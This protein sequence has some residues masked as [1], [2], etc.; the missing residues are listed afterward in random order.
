[1]ERSLALLE[2]LIDE[3][4]A[5]PSASTI[6][7]AVIKL[8]DSPV[9]E[10]VE[11]PLSL[12]T[13]SEIQKAA[14]HTSASPSALPESLFFSAPSTLATALSSIQVSSTES[15]KPTTSAPV[16]VKDAIET[17]I[18]NASLFNTMKSYYVEELPE[19]GTVKANEKIKRRDLEC[20]IKMR[21]LVK[22]LVEADE[23]NA[24]VLHQVTSLCGGAKGLSF[25]DKYDPDTYFIR[26]RYGYK[27]RN[28]ENKEN[29]DIASRIDFEALFR[30][31][32]LIDAGVKIPFEFII[33]L[34]SLNK[35]LDHILY[36]ECQTGK[37]SE[38]FEGMNKPLGDVS[39]MKII[40]NFVIQEYPKLIFEKFN[41]EVQE[42]CSIRLADKASVYIFSRKFVILGELLHELS[43]II[44]DIKK[45]KKNNLFSLFSRFNGLRNGFVHF[46]FHVILYSLLQE[47][48]LEPVQAIISQILENL[49]CLCNE[50]KSLTDEIEK[51]QA[52]KLCK[53]GLDDLLEL[54]QPNKKRKLRK[55]LIEIVFLGNH[56]FE[57]LESRAYKNFKVFL[58]ENYTDF[59]SSKAREII[60]MG[61]KNDNPSQLLALESCDVGTDKTV[62]ELFK[63]FLDELKSF[64][65]EKDLQNFKREY[66]LL[67]E[68]PDNQMFIVEKFNST[69][70]LGFEIDAIKFGDK[71]SIKQ[72]LVFHKEF[73]K[74]P[75][76]EAAKN[77]S[78]FFNKLHQAL[79]KHKITTPN[80]SSISKRYKDAK[81]KLS[82]LELEDKIELEKE[83]NFSIVLDDFEEIQKLLK[84]ESFFDHFGNSVK[85]FTGMIIREMNYLSEI[86]LNPTLFMQNCI[87]EH[88]ITLVG[89]YVRDIED[90]ALDSEVFVSYTSRVAGKTAKIYRNKG[91]AH[92]LFDFNK[93]NFLEGL[94]ANIYPAVEDFQAIHLIADSRSEIKM[95]GSSLIYAKLGWSYAQLSF[96]KEA[97]DFY[98]KA[99]ESFSSEIPK[100]EFN[101]NSLVGQVYLKGAG[102]TQPQG[103]LIDF[104][105]FVFGMS[106]FELYCYTNLQRICFRSGNLEKV[107]DIYTLFTSQI[108]L[109]RVNKYQKMLADPSIDD[110]GKRDN[111]SS[112]E[113]GLSELFERLIKSICSYQRPYVILSDD[114][115]LFGSIADVFAGAACAERLNGNYQE[116]VKLLSYSVECIIVKIQR[117]KPDV[118]HIESF[119]VEK[120]MNYYFELAQCHLKLNQPKEALF[121]AKSV[122][123]NG[124]IGARLAARAVMYFIKCKLETITDSVIE[125]YNVEINQNLNLLKKNYGDGF[126]NYLEQFYSVTLDYYFYKHNPKEMQVFL[127]KLEEEFF[128]QYHMN[129]YK[130]LNGLRFSIF[131]SCI[132]AL[133]QSLSKDAYKEVLD[134]AKKYFKLL[135][136]EMATLSSKCKHLAKRLATAINNYATYYFVINAA[137]DNTLE[138]I[139]DKMRNLVEAFNIQQK[140][141]ID[142]NV[143]LTN[144]C[145]SYDEKVEY[146][147][148]RNKIL[149]LKDVLEWMKYID[150][151]DVQ[152]L[153]PDWVTA[154]HSQHASCFETLAKINRS[155]KNKAFQN[156]SGA[157]LCAEKSLLFMANRYNAHIYKTNIKEGIFFSSSRY[158]TREMPY[159]PYFDRFCSSDDPVTIEAEQCSRLS[160][161][162]T[163]VIIQR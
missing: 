36:N 34:R 155:D 148:H 145:A 52:L 115:L 159:G 6:K 91:L 100:D 21:E 153:S 121:F 1:M 107:F 92:E 128:D 160:K 130:R 76:S 114:K 10:K 67:L 46:N 72:T 79:K 41:L 94:L 58:Q 23:I 110:E 78:I 69:V 103:I 11:N 140:Y 132:N 13:Q 119:C 63:N 15:K 142:T 4:A 136:I 48:M 30:I 139:S 97:Q 144:I 27:K 102:L 126:F 113:P 71:E 104:N 106:N 85:K 28:Q 93:Q 98:E 60:S 111:L 138:L 33:D 26:N 42:I 123:E 90:R 143:I 14:K 146:Y 152:Q 16:E 55:K 50:S 105:K 122:I 68:E 89:Q 35:K 82:E 134:I 3:A 47:K 77:F 22:N 135:E 32:A 129:L 80:L 86:E 81:I 154:L 108:N 7:N 45:Q 73:L 53:K 124:E 54:M 62:Q 149:S 61:L 17:P 66:L 44:P 118:M 125:D 19:R 31:K 127:E 117:G 39:N 151:V 29:D 43:E 75:D 18:R 150:M 56:L 120:L 96:L 163:S 141:H 116:A 57:I 87:I 137:Q 99:L 9:A 37:Y 20:L 40:R 59:S 88:I 109:E 74:E 156:Y 158:A 12:N 64:I 65:L 24:Q 95:R 112:I 157:L 70:I 147:L 2:K 101:E 84:Q 131:N 49:S 161:L 8:T 25:N 162:K 5:L 133:N 51:L 83:F 38:N